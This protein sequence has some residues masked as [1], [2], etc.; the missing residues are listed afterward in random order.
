MMK[1]FQVAIGIPILIGLTALRGEKEKFIGEQKLSSCHA[2]I[3][4]YYSSKRQEELVKAAKE[5]EN[6]EIVLVTNEKKGLASYKFYYIET[7]EGAYGTSAFLVSPEDHN[8]ES[9]TR[10]EFFIDYKPKKHTFYQADCFRE[11]LKEHEELN[12]TLKEKK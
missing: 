8:S 3:P 5:F 11:K 6:V 7:Y 4:L 9:K 1:L 2:E 12:K 10:T